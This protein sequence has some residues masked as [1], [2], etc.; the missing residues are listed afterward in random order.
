MVSAPSIA[1]APPAAS[2]RAAAAALL[3]ESRLPMHEPLAP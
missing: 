2:Q 1:I 3:V